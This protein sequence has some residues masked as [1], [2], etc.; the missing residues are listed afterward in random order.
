MRQ[1]NQQQVRDSFNKAANTY[2]SV[3]ELQQETSL[4]LLERLRLIKCQPQRIL[5]LGSG[6]GFA[7]PRLQEIYPTAEIISLDLA[8]KMLQV[9]NYQRCRNFSLCGDIQQLPILS[10]SIDLVFSNLSLQ[11]C[12]L[13]LAFP[14]IA[15]VLNPKGLFIF[16]TMGPDTLKEFRYSWSQVDV[17]SHVNLF[18]DMHD[19]GDLMLQAGLVDPVLDMERCVKKYDSP[20]TAM[21]VLK[22]LGAHNL[23]AQRQRG[24]MGRNKIQ[25]FISAY[26]KFTD[27]QGQ[28]PLTYEVIYGFS[29]GVRQQQNDPDVA[30]FPIDKIK[31]LR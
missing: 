21:T 5:D 25:Q 3:G 1:F 8:E 6:T 31:R 24:L 16:T 13:Q 15:R 28:F 9:E 30:E 4:Q 27:P 26:E 10:G 23:T 12:D 2:D 14:E 22:A 29:W 20:R 7:L 19:V 11:W 17:G 18:Y